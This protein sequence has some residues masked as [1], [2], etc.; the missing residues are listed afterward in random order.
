MA[1][2]AHSLAPAAASFFTK[3]FAN[4]MQFGGQ[5]DGTVRMADLMGKWYSEASSAPPSGHNVGTQPWAESLHAFIEIDLKNAF[6]DACR[7]AA[8]DT[9]SGVA[10]KSYDQDNVQI[11][12]ALPCLPELQNF[13]GYFRN[14][15]DTASTLRYLDPSGSTHHIDGTRGGQQGDP[16]E[17]YRFSHTIHPLWG[18]VMAR[19][20]DARAV[21]YADDGFVKD[22]LLS[23]LRILAELKF[24]FK[25]DLGMELT[26]HK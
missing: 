17:M 25:Q 15:H 3:T 16:L 11:G 14:M 26:L 12:D 10:T 24:A 13:F 9:L 23:V 19:F 18:R 5:R 2:A 22:R 21:A 4:F 6:N 1:C 20:P 7:Q 8:F